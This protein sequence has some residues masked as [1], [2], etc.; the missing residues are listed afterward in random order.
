MPDI[1]VKGG[2]YQPEEIAGGDCVRR[3]GGDVCTIDF[4]DGHST[5]SIIDRINRHLN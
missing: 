2:D 3:N 4:V 5:T 1:L